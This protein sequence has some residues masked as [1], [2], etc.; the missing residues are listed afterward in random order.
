VWKA[1]D[2][3]LA[4]WVALKLLKGADEEE[5]DRFTREARTAGRLNHPNIAAVYD[6]GRANDRHFIAMQLVPGRTLRAVERRDPRE[7]ARL[8]RDAARAVAHAHAAGVVHRDL[9]P[10]NI[11]L[12]PEGR[13]FVMDFG[14]ARS[15]TP[16]ARHD[17]LELPDD[18]HPPPLVDDD[19]HPP[20]ELEPP[21]R[22]IAVVLAPELRR[23]APARPRP[24]RGV[25]IQRHDARLGPAGTY[26]IGSPRAR[27]S[28]ST[29]EGSSTR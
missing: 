5:I 17:R 8:V 16:R 28:G 25:Q 15:V 23:A 21:R 4:R 6:A 7:L 29:P 3:E 2:S 24:R 10:D 20:L 18:P 12:T 13:V 9:K 19:P 27:S 22:R 26:S 1:W 14:L 11:M